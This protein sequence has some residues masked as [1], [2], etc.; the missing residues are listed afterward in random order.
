MNRVVVLLG[1]LAGA[2]LAAAPVSATTV[3]RDGDKYQVDT[4]TADQAKKKIEAAGYRGVKELKKGL[5]SVWH[6]RASKDGKEARVALTP[7]GGVYPDGD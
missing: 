4:S 7:D 1:A 3:T 6:G 2:V 5:D